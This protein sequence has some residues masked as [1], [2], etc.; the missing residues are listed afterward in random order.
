MLATLDVPGRVPEQRSVANM[1]E[2][3]VGQNNRSDVCGRDADV[4]ELRTYGS[5]NNAPD[6]V[7][8]DPAA[9][10]FCDFVL[11]A[12]VP[13][14]PL[15]FLRAMPPETSMRWPVTEPSVRGI[16]ALT[17]SGTARLRVGI[18]LNIGHHTIGLR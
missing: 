18:M 10:Y 3:S 6:V 13:N 12:S 7:G 11:N 8:N 14:D 2:M 5:N 9:R 15:A 17:Q 4:R 1:I 16:N